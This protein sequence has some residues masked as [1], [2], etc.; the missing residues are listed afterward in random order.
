MSC[1]G[2]CI[3]CAMTK[4]LSASYFRRTWSPQCRNKAAGHT[5][6]VTRTGKTLAG[7]KTCWPC[8]GQ[9]LGGLIRLDNS[10]L[11]LSYFYA[12]CS[13]LSSIIQWR[14]YW[15]PILIRAFQRLQTRVGLLSHRHCLHSMLLFNMIQ[16]INSL[17]L[18]LL[19][20][21][22]CKPHSCPSPVLTRCYTV[23]VSPGNNH[24]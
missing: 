2:A 15:T 4:L 24:Y 7:H 17:R 13:V 21:I 1:W 9:H 10:F 20:R 22:G 23:R 8:V 5:I 11:L 3:A 12:T 16:T 18:V 19:Y 14:R 6:F